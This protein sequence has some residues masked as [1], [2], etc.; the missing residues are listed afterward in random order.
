MGLAGQV[1]EVPEHALTVGVV[2][3]ERLGMELRPPPATL[4]R[5]DRLGGAPGRARQDPEIRWKLDDLVEVILV[6]GRPPRQ[7]RQKVAVVENLERQVAALGRAPGVG[8]GCDT[9]P[10]EAS[11]QLQ[12]GADPEHR[13]VGRPDRMPKP[14]EVR[15]DSARGVTFVARRP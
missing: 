15:G 12:P 9:P 10:G 5:G 11:E 4:R 7:A 1:E 6:D 2:V 3:V 8:H 13:P 14:V